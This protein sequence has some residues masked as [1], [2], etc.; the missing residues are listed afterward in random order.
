MRHLVLL[1]EVLYLAL[2][3]TLLILFLKLLVVL[4]LS[5]T[6]GTFGDVA[7]TA[8]L[9]LVV[10]GLNIIANWF[11]LRVRNTSINFLKIKK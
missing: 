1:A 11:L 9:I 5:M 6:Y 2:T 7:T 3:I 10:M 8:T 4:F